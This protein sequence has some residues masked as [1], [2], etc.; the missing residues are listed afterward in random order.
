MDN[1]VSRIKYNIQWCY[2]AL[3]QQSLM[4]QYAFYSNK[5][6]LQRP[7]FQPEKTT[8]VEANIFSKYAN[9]DF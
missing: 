2:L 9:S 5:K 3:Q 1:L 8:A 7:L 4:Q 6:D